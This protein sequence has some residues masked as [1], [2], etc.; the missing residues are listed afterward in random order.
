MGK[1][2][3]GGGLRIKATLQGTEPPIWRRLLI[4]SRM[5]L[6]DLHDVL[7]AAMG[8]EDYHL[9]EFRI[10][11]A[12][13]SNPQFELDDSLPEQSARLGS[14]GLTEGS[15]FSY[16]YDFGDDWE[17]GIAVEEIL[18][19]TEGVRGPRCLAGAR[20]GPPEDCGG[21]WGYEEMLAAIGD[22]DH[23]DH[24]DMLAWVGGAF[25]PDAFDV[26][27]LNRE[28]NAMAR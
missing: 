28:L 19:D 23:D 15:T 26:D 22:P 21:V 10:G 3:T 12:R 14:L 20:A 7:Q 24:D 11:E 5:T 6:A 9:H 8:W 1:G 13:Y 16:T 17:I 27:A 4:P 25:D 2:T 18:P